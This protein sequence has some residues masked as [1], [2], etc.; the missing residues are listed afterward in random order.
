MNSSSDTINSFN[1]F[2]IG[3]ASATARTISAKK[4]SQYSYKNCGT[5]SGVFSQ[6]LVHGNSNNEIRNYEIRRE[7]SVWKEVK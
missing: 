6:P 3:E 5:H 2:L 1:L 7:A 4:T